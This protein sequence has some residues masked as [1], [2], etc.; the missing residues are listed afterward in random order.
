MLAS[1][2]K[3]FDRQALKTF[4]RYRIF[5]ASMKGAFMSG[6]T[7]TNPD[8]TAAPPQSTADAVIIA[9]QS[10]LQR[11][12]FDTYVDEPPPMGRGGKGVVVT[13]CPLC[14]KRLNTMAQ[15]MDHILLDVVPGAV[16]KALG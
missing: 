11:H 12:T 8:P 4:L 3:A 9:I 14:N 13:G 1:R 6:T 15:F 7:G 2:I 5:A 10:E 16:R